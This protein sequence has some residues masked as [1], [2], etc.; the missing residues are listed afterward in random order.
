[1]INGPFESLI[2][3]VGL[4][5]CMGIFLHINGNWEKM[6]KLMF[7][8]RMFSRGILQNLINIGFWGSD[9]TNFD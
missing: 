2:R 6:R 9:K 8:Q 1:M 4:P 5:S 7:A 3:Q